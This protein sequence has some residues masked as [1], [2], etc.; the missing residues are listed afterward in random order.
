MPALTIILRS[1][2]SKRMKKEYKPAEME[3][4]V[5]EAEDV[6]TESPTKTIDQDEL[7]GDTTPKF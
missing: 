6:I 3:I 5:F 7:Y 4:I 1:C 2:G